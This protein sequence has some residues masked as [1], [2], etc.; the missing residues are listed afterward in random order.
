VVTL[1][2]TAI[3]LLATALVFIRY[4]SRIAYWI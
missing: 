3:N 4:R 2:I 1:A